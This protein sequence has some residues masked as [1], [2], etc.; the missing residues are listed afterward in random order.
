MLLKGKKA[1]IFGVVNDR[2]I[3]Y[4]IARQF[5]QRTPLKADWN[6]SVKNWVAKCCSSAT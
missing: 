5:T 6:P 1:L 4:G 2:S 3:A